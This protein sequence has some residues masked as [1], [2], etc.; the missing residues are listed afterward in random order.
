LIVRGFGPTAVRCGAEQGFLRS[1]VMGNNRNVV[2]IAPLAGLLLGVLDFVWIKYVPFPFGD[3]GNS[4]A[5]W[6][7]AA[8]LLTWRSRWSLPVGVA[9]AV[10]SLVVAVPSYYLAAALIQHD[11][12]SNLFN[13]VS[14]VW[15]GLGVVAGIVFGAAGVIARKPGHLR[16]V[17][18]AMP[19]AVLF[20]EAVI[21]G[22]RIGDP[23]YETASQLEVMAVLIG[24]GLAITLW[25][26]R[27]W[28]QRALALLFALPLTA[29][30]WALLTVTGFR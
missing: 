8:F 14:F 5:V 12:W 7:V 2:W 29:V 6:A 27:S 21:N 15:M 24:L 22:R 23:S 3:L 11:A 18:S 30:G 1:T 16:T 28:P 25:V 10:V 26:G 17:A 19:G 13:G 20:A 4:M 9:G